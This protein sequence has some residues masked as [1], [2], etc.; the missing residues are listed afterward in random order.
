MVISGWGKS[1]SKFVIGGK[2]FVF[3]FFQKCQKINLTLVT[4]EVVTESVYSGQGVP[5]HV[6]ATAQIKIKTSF[7]DDKGNQVADTTS[8]RNAC[9]L[10]LSKGQSKLMNIAQATLEGHQRAV[11]GTM[12]VEEVYQDRN[13]FSH[14]V[15]KMTADDLASMGLEV[16]SYTISEVSDDQGYLKAIGMERTA[17]VQSNASIAKAVQQQLAAIEE[18][19]ANQDS[20]QAKYENLI[21]TAE[22]DK[23]FKLK[24]SEFDI[25]VETKRAEQEASHPMQTAI[26]NQAVQDERMKIEVVARLKEIQLQGQE[27]TRVKRELEGKVEKVAEAKKYQIEQLAQAELTEKVLKAK[28]DAE[29]LQAKG[30]AEAYA[31]E[32]KG[33]ADADAM[34]KKA[35][36]LQGFR[37]AA[38][39]SLVLKSLPKVAAEIAAPLSEL[40]KLTMV[41]GDDGDVG[42]SRMTNEVL[43]IM[44]SIPDAIKSMTGVDL[45]DAIARAAQN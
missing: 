24:Q 37:G 43:T 7:T 10:F 33:E 38:I 13:K 30:K 32:A 12:T 9:R 5:I 42:A 25:E 36:A 15:R 17:Q 16:V 21:T 44:N 26:T 29:A 35:K 1:P 2:S 20:L 18:A 23:D 11:I 3:P 4:C 14:A 28:S 8:L 22:S 19:K 31:I 39:L 40:D 45:S 27:I 34:L 41:A 6:T